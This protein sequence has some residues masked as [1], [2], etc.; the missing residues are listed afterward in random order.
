MRGVLKKDLTA[1]QHTGYLGTSRVVLNHFDVSTQADIQHQALNYGSEDEIMGRLYGKEKRRESSGG[2][3]LYSKQDIRE[4]YCISERGLGAL[5]NNKQ[6]IFGCISSHHSSPCSTRSAS[7]LLTA[8]VK[9]KMSSDENLYELYKRHPSE[10]APFPKRQRYPWMP[11]TPEIYRHDVDLKSSYFRRKPLADPSRYTWMPSDDESVR[12][13]KPKSIL[14]MSYRNQIPSNAQAGKKHVSFARSHTLTSFDDAMSSLTSSS[15]HLNR[16]TRSQE[17]LLEVRKAEEVRAITKQPESENVVILDKIKRAPMKTQ[18]TQTEVGLGRKPINPGNIHLSPRTIQKVKMVSQAAQTNGYNG[19]KLAKS[20]SEASNKLIISPSK[21]F[22]FFE[23]EMDH[24]PLQRTQ[25]DEPPRSPFFVMTPPTAYLPTDNP[26]QSETS[27]LSKSEDHESED[28]VESKQEIFIDF[29]PQVPPT[30]D[31]MSKR[32]L[33]KTASDGVIL[34]HQRKN[35]LEDDGVVPNIKKFNSISHENIP[36]VEEHRTFTPYFQ[37]APIRN[38]GICKPLED[39]IYSSTDVCLFTQDSIDEEFHENFIFNK[40]YI[41]RQDSQ[42]GIT[43]ATK[44][45]T[46][47]NDESVV[48]SISLRPEL[49]LSPFTSNDDIRDQSD[50]NWNES[51]VTVLQADSGTD[52]GTPFSS[53]EVVSASSPVSINLLTPASRRKELLI[54]QHQ[55]RSSM[56]IETLDEELGDAQTQPQIVV[57]KFTSKLEVPSPVSPKSPSPSL[58]KVSHQRTSI[59]LNRPKRTESPPIQLESPLPAV[60][61]DLLLARTDSCKTN[62]DVSES[63]TTD[64]YITAN[65]GT[66]SSKKSGSYKVVPSLSPSYSSKAPSETSSVAHV[67]TLAPLP[68]I[69]SGRST[70]SDDSSSCG[71]YSVGT[72]I[73]DLLDRYSIPSGSPNK[74][75][76][77]SEDDER[78]VHYSSS[79]YYESPI[80]D[81]FTLKTSRHEERTKKRRDFHLELTTTTTKTHSSNKPKLKYIESKNTPGSEQTPKFLGEKVKRSKS[82]TRS[83]MQGQKKNIQGRRSPYKEKTVAYDEKNYK[84]TSDESSTGREYAGGQSSPRKNKKSKDNNRRRSLPRSPIRQKSEKR[85]S[86]DYQPSSLP[87][88]L[89]R[90]KSFKQSKSLQS[91]HLDSKKPSSKSPA[92]QKNA[93][94]SKETTT[95]KALSAESLRSVSPGSDSVFYSDPSSHTTDHQIH[96][97]HCGKEVSNSLQVDLATDDPDKSIS[98]NG[99]QPDIVRPPAGFEDSPKL[100]PGRL[101]K[102]LDKRIKSEERSQAEGK[103][104]KYRPDARAKSEERSGAAG[105]VVKSKL[106]PMARSPYCSKEQLKTANSSPSILPGDPE[107]DDD[108]GVYNVSYTTGLWLYVDE[109]DELQSSSILSPTEQEQIRRTS[110]SSTESEQDFRKRY[111]AITHRMVHRKSCLEMYKKQTNKSF[112]YGSL[113]C[114]PSD[115]CMDLKQRL[116]EV[117]KLMLLV[118]CRE[119][120]ALTILNPENKNE[121][122]KTVVVHRESGEFGFRIHGSKPVVVSAIEPGTPAESSGLEV[123]DIVLSVNGVSVLDKSHSEV[124]KIAHAG[125]DTLTLEVAR[126]CYALNTSNDE[127]TDNHGCYSGYLWKLSGYASGTMSNKWIRR[128]FCLKQNNCLYYYKTDSEKQPVGVVMLFEHDIL[129]LNDDENGLYK[130]YRFVVQ[131]EDSVPLHLAADTE[132]ARSRWVEVIG[133][134]IHDSYV[135]DEFLDQTKRNLN[136]PPSSIEDPDCFGYLIKLGNQWKSWSRR[137][138]V[139]K[140][141]CLYFYLD[142]NASSAFGVAY[143]HGYRVQQSSSGSKKHAFEIIPPETGQKSYYFHAESETDKKRWITAVE[144]SIDKWLKVK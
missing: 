68:Q 1:D 72:S 101:F 5:E 48:P 62:T 84:A 69:I 47:Q 125:S 79:G 74:T 30:H 90:R 127:H 21:E 142:A 3:T 35:H 65:S 59:L 44:S 92:P 46:P 13:E 83:P 141:A 80:E 6:S 33:V 77:G 60:V 133:K 76:H 118:W 11:L 63:T 131:R 102:K 54:L 140:D 53:S 86:S 19:R 91:I 143:L 34:V 51:Q 23:P 124:V 89:C 104:N 25:S 56:D 129:T 15:S 134:A 98:S 26:A 39:N 82:R 85:N 119:N 55:Q 144:Y 110:V 114:N 100:K 94:S 24:E 95:L 122:D 107:E 18:A 10:Y 103:R 41:N 88:S 109:R 17:R 116:E 38:E 126:T 120:K 29:K 112:G 136:L 32:P 130:P 52:N 57:E 139:L 36:V 9:Q 81:E 111:Q 87:G 2:S 128:W 135:V 106:R 71:S 49:K 22:N 50:G 31:K 115:E 123:G 27:S 132:G 108:Q 45:L 70:P 97:L 96:C 61:P 138:C 58:L 16:I 42:N 105:G 28:S 64:D 4:Q 8:C 14:D 121:C 137:Y 20:L 43:E 75:W 7:S 37:K 78:S 12:M 73:P 40:N 99:H 93:N 67:N 66:D 117:L 113:Q